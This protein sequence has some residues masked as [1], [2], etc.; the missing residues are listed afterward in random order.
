VKGFGSFDKPSRKA[1]PLT[2]GVEF[3]VPDTKSKRMKKTDTWFPFLLNTSVVEHTHR[4]FPLSIWVG[5]ASELFPEGIVYVNSEDA[6]KAKISEGDEVV[7]TSADF[8]KTWPVRVGSK[9]PEGTLHV[10]LRQGESVGS[11]PHPVK[12]RKKNV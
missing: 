5:G 9:Q 11:N 12:I 2:C 3:V 1:T 10:T 4:G 6:K 8:G 7:V